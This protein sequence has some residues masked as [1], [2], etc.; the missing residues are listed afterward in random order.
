MKKLS[1][2]LAFLILCSCSVYQGNP[3]A[4]INNQQ[5]GA[6]EELS[7]EVDDSEFDSLI[8]DSRRHL[9]QDGYLILIG[10]RKSDIPASVADR[11][12][13]QITSRLIKIDGS[14][15]K[16]IVIVRERWDL[17]SFSVGEIDMPFEISLDTE[18]RRTR[19]TV[20]KMNYVLDFTNDTYEQIVEYRKEDILSD[21]SRLLAESTDGSIQ[22]YSTFSFNQG[23]SIFGDIVAYDTRN[24][25]IQFLAPFNAID[26]QAIFVWAD[27]VLISR[28]NELLLLDARTGELL[29]NTPQFDYGEKDEERGL[30][31]YVTLGAV[32]HPQR[33]LLYIAFGPSQAA[34]MLNPLSGTRPLSFAVFN[35]DGRMIEAFDTPFSIEP[36]IGHYIKT[37]NIVLN[38]DI[39]E[40]R[41]FNEYGSFIDNSADGERVFFGEVQLNDF[42]HRSP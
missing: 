1:C 21:R 41:P 22:V 15:D 9:E 11:N 37:V 23:A 17:F 27:Q 36:H 5:N 24:G 42:E 3:P 8:Q 14:F 30:R 28:H 19:L 16:E 32:Y 20:Q 25:D 26:N 4:P 34:E 35:M 13:F 33:E 2:L 7:Q 6:S 31:E 10:S 29:P 18:E 40:I 39:I 12:L 38:G